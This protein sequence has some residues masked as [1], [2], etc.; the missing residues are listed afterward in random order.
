MHKVPSRYQL[1]DIATKPQPRALFESQ[2]ESIMQWEAED[3]TIEELQLPAKHLRAC[4]IIE[5][6]PSL[7]EEEALKK[8]KYQH[9][10]QSAGSPI[11]GEPLA[12]S[13]T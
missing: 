5:Q 9:A 3:M 10:G 12:G 4:D 2:R 8:S 7:C 6:L 13:A 1:G 11:S